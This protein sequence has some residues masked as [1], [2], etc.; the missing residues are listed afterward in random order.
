[1]GAPMTN[2]PPVPPPWIGY[3]NPYA[4]N[5]PTGLIDTYGLDTYGTT[6]EIQNSIVKTAL[7]LVGSTAWSDQVENGNYAT[8]T[9]KCNK[10]VSDVL[11]WANASPGTPNGLFHKYPPTAGQWAD[12]S[13]NIPGWHI[14]SPGTTTP[15]A[16]DIVAQQIPY[17]DASGHVM[18]VGPNGTVIGTGDGNTRQ[19]H[20]T[21]EQIPIPKSLGPNPSGPLIYRRFGP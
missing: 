20:G 18:I 6:Q 7:G 1:M 17:S 13:Y 14:I 19:P 3:S 10:F 9:N 21:V 5:N 2:V 15:Q 16:G 8:G 4:L 11:G 12:P